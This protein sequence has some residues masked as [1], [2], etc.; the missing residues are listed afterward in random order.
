MRFSKGFVSLSRSWLPG[1]VMLPVGFVVLVAVG[2]YL[3]AD[4][5]VQDKP[6][7]GREVVRLMAEPIELK[8]DLALDAPS[9]EAP[10]MVRAIEPT[11]VYRPGATPHEGASQGSASAR[12]AETATVGIR[13]RAMS[14]VADAV[15]GIASL[16]TGVERFDHC[17]ADCESRDPLVMRTTYVATATGV[18]RPDGIAGSRADDDNVFALPALPEAGELVDMGVQGATAVYDSVKGAVSGVIDLLR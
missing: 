18:V 4:G 8:E 9:R 15:A 12:S 13:E 14:H 11:A 2:A 6:A 17:G 1:R 10:T 7:D 5:G 3:A 16:P